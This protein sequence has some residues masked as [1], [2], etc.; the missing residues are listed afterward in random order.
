MNKTSFLK[1]NLMRMKALLHIFYYPQVKIEFPIDILKQYIDCKWNLPKD[2]KICSPD[3]TVDKQAWADL[4]NSDG[5]FGIWNKKRVEEEVISHM[6]TQD[7]ASLLYYKDKLIGC[8]STMRDIN[9][10]IKIGIGMFLLLEKSH[11]SK[12]GLSF[13]LTF[14]TLSFFARENFV[15]AFAYTDPHRLSALYLYLS[16]GIKPKYNSISSIFQWYMIKKRLNPLLKR[17]KRKNGE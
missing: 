17:K 4:L 12:K 15:K 14:R 9:S 3:N 7:A 5:E 16:N 11:R 2:Y 6:I 13:A 10:K 8:S 1:K